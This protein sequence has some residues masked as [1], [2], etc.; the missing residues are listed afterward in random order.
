MSCIL[1]ACP[2]QLLFPVHFIDFLDALQIKAEIC[3]NNVIIPFEKQKSEDCIKDEKGLRAVD[4][5]NNEWTL[6]ELY[7]YWKEIQK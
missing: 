1:C 7:N 5:D 3:C 2:V 6:D 4:D